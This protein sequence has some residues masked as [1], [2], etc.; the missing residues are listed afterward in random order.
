MTPNVT[1]WSW[2]ELGA[3]AVHTWMGVAHTGSWHTLLVVAHTWWLSSPSVDLQT[4]CC[5]GE[6]EAQPRH[7]LQRCLGVCSALMAIYVGTEGLCALLPH[8]L[9]LSCVVN[10]QLEVLDTP[11][12][13]NLRPFTLS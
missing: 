13:T 7:A 1:G 9:I 5:F 4:P 11:E 2:S 10:T 6:K 8:S 12:N 3:L